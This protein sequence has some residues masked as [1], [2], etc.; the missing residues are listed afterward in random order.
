MLRSEKQATRSSRQSQGRLR[1]ETLEPRQML[2]GDGLTGEYFNTITL[3]DLANTRIDS[4]VNF[5]GDVLGAG[6]QGQVTADD[7]YSIR[8]TGWVH[9]EQAGS[10]QFTTFSN[11][12]VRLWVDDTQIINNWTQHASTR[13]DGSI[14]LAAGWHPIRMEYFQQ[15]GTTDARLLFSG[16][17]KSETII[18]QTHLSSTDPN[19]GDPVANAGPNR[20]VILPSMRLLAVR[21]SEVAP[22]NVAVFGPLSCD[23]W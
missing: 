17:G 11:D 15:D 6:A 19:I 12:G 13:D 9:A 7:N 10:W 2:T 21:S 20:V 3:T 14:S 22:P 23:H 5:P 16:P 4:V 1:F 18:P 8:W